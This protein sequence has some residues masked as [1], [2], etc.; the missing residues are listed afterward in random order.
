M[1]PRGE[2]NRVRA[3]TESFLYWICVMP[4]GSYACFR[5][6]TPRPRPPNESDWVPKRRIQ[7]V[8][9]VQNEGGVLAGPGP[10]DGGLGGSEKWEKWGKCSINI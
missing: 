6:A 8:F 9:G 4:S 3:N 2:I 10:G 1:G 7:M 5:C